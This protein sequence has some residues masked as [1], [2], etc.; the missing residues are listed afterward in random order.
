MIPSTLDTWVGGKQQRETGC[1]SKCTHIGQPLDDMQPGF[2]T[3]ETFVNGVVQE[4]YI[5]Q[6]GQMGLRGILAL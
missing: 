2:F 1:S 3:V 6:I 4:Q 5:S